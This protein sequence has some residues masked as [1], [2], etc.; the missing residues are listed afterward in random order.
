MINTV[1]PEE[2]LPYEKVPSYRKARTSRR[3]AAGVVTCRNRGCLFIERR[4]KAVG[5]DGRGRDIV[6]I[7]V[8]ETVRGITT[9][10]GRTGRKG[11]GIIHNHGR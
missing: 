4:E 10:G 1:F 9:Y 5:V 7:E 8:F 2:V 11:D 3:L 6:V